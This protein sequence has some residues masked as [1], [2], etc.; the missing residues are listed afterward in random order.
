MIEADGIFVYGTLR[1]GGRY[2]PWLDRTSPQGTTPAWAPGRLFHL[3]G[4]SLSASGASARTRERSIDGAGFPA[5]VAGPIPGILPPSTGWVRGE[6]VGYEDEADLEAALENLDQLEGVAED[7][8][9]RR[10]LPVLLDSGAHYVAWVYVFP[11]DRLPRLEREG[12]E[13]ADGDWAGYLED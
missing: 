6:F 1:E 2:R 5:M 4:G 10:L 7:L 3:P 8:F 13:L 11:A 12:I 9:E